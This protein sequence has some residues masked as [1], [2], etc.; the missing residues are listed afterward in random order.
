MFIKLIDADA[1]QA[2]ADLVR[3]LRMLLEDNLSF[4][5]QWEITQSD[6][7][8]VRERFEGD[9]TGFAFT[10]PGGCDSLCVHVSEWRGLSDVEV[11]AA[12]AAYH[13]DREAAGHGLAV[14]DDEHKLL[15]AYRA[16]GIPLGVGAA[17]AGAGTGRGNG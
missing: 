4:P 7:E 2:P 12:I 8:S 9:E 17:S 16:L 10:P 6:D 1:I 11:D 15:A 5:G 13:D 14:T 3:V